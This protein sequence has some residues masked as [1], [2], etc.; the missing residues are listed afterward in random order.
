MAADILS[1][2][3]VSIDVLKQMYDDAYMETKI[4][5]DGD[6]TVREGFLCLVTIT[7]AKE[8]V[9]LSTYFAFKDDTDHIA[10][11]E[12]SNRINDGIVTVRAAVTE[13]GSLVLDLYVPI[14]GGITKRCLVLGTKYFLNVARAALQQCDTE[15]IVK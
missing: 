1:S 5:S 10:K 7:E 8:Q 15:D 14:N 12:M 3:N 2:E 13:R 4:D 11:I 6:L 9:R